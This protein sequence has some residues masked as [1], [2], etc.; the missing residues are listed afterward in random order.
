[1]GDVKWEMENVKW[2]MGDVKWE[3]RKTLQLELLS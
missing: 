3:M 1:M 2:K